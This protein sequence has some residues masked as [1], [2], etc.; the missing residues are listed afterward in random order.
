MTV[1]PRARI[2]IVD[3]HEENLI[4]LEAVLEDQPFDIVR[5]TSG[6]AALREALKTDFAVV[7][8]D[9]AMPDMD[10][11][12]TATLLRE[13]ERSRQT[14][15]I[16]LT[17][18]YRGDDHM[19]RGYAIGAVD[20]L[21]KPFSPDI[22]KTKVRHFVDFFE[23]TA[24]LQRAHDELEE[25]VRERTAELAAANA[26][27]RE[28]REQA[29]HVNRLKDEF[30]ATMS[31]EL[32]TP[33]NAIIGWTHLLASPT[34]DP[35]MAV[36]AVTVIKNNA[37][38]QAQIIE[39]ILDV[40]RIISGRLTLR[41]AQVSVHEVVNAAVD[42]VVPAAAAKGI[43]IRR[44]I[45]VLEPVILDR[46]R[47]HQ[48][49]WNLLSNAVK[50]TPK[51]GS[52]LVTLERRG[53]DL[54]I[55]V[56]DTGIGITKPF[57]PYIFDRFSQADGSAKR[58]HGGLGLGMAIV[59]HLVELHGGTVHAQS[60]GTDQ[61]AMFTVVLPMRT[62]LL[63]PHEES[64]PVKDVASDV[65]S[66][67]SLAREHVLLV[68]DDRDNREFLGLLLR[69]AG[70][71][72]S[73]AINGASALQV[74][75]A[76]QI[77]M[78]VSDLTMPTIDGIDLIRK[79]RSMPRLAG[80]PAIALTAHIRPREAKE[81]LEAGFDLHLGKPVDLAQLIAAIDTLTST[82]HVP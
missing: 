41:L 66:M 72:V 58:K 55:I 21:T 39:D 3:D 32:R 31:H 51:G 80:L 12:E 46:D 1:A 7:L 18:N 69:Q 79:V 10:G 78:L 13:R 19:F 25:R 15:I 59:R 45:A 11:F 42:T 57:V 68:D 75:E 17:A 60:A 63:Q 9:V 22:L 56:T 81:A 8:L 64:A 71:R 67:P 77:T 82:R 28:L 27:E 62:A 73:T 76:Q 52:V 26:V 37:L 29:E 40:S 36:R 53:D 20:Y 14:P 35:E 65:Q 74:L 2:L 38:A 30:L 23:K 44:Q 43:T 24:A 49:C 48:V 47:V 70:A 16:F 33:L 54:A 34:D 50:F 5:A 6:R 4:A 61:G